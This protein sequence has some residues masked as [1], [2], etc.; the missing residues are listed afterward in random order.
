[1]IK[2]AILNNLLVLWL[3][4]PGPK[5][6]SNSDFKALGNIFSLILHLKEE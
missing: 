2:R 3:W 1:M 6:V 5:G 4:I